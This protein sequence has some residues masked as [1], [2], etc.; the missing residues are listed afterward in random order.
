M[1]NERW[2]ASIIAVE[3]CEVYVLSRA[4]F[5]YALMPYPDILTHLQNIVLARPEKT[6]L[7]EKIREDSPTTM[8]GSIDISSIKVK[9]KD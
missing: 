2:I 8:S 4:V 6:P 7:L 5:Q 1:E 3:N 9:K